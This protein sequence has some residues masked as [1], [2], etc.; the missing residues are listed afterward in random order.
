VKIR[1]SLLDHLS[2]GQRRLATLGARLNPNDPNDLAAAVPAFVQLEKQSAFVVYISHGRWQAGQ[3]EMGGCA[4][5]A[6][7]PISHLR[8][9]VQTVMTATFRPAQTWI[10]VHHSV[11]VSSVRI[12]TVSTSVRS[13]RLSHGFT[14]FYVHSKVI[15]DSVPESFHAGARGHFFSGG[16]VFSFDA[17]GTLVA[18]NTID[19]CTHAVMLVEGQLCPD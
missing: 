19:F 3:A 5:L 15:P 8:Q 13:H 17:R 11:A 1:G 7:Q 10:I 6:S 18:T 9:P 12:G 14:V 16:T 2:G 4:L